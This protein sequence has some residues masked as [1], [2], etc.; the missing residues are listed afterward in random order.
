MN[1]VFSI[2]FI[3]ASRVP[4]SLRRMAA[5]GTLGYLLL[6]FSLSGVF[7]ATSVFS[8]LEADR[9]SRKGL[10]SAVSWNSGETATQETEALYE[11]ALT[12][13]NQLNLSVKQAGRRFPWA[14]KLEGLLRTLPGRT[15]ILSLS[16]AREERVLSLEAL[17]LIDSEKPYELPTKTW[18]QA[19]KSDPDF[20]QGLKRIELVNSF[21][22]TQGSAELFSFVLLME[23]EAGHR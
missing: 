6:N 7:V 15:W 17:Y 12:T 16:G 23:W 4:I 5:Y 14:E 22:K 21:R 18:I 19:L 20:G 10:V 11:Q 8:S 1:Q 13:L 9:L 3:R 2:N